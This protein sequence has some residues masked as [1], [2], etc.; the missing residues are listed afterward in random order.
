M[1]PQEGACVSTGG[2]QCVSTGGDMCVH[3][4]GHVCPQEGD[5]CVHRRGHVC[6]HEGTVC[7]LRKVSDVAGGR[8][9]SP[10]AVKIT[11]D[12]AVDQSELRHW[13]CC[14]LDLRVFREWRTREMD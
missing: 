10:R 8:R 9:S 7:V 3:R 14:G 11:R 5:V 12:V 13:G 6:P 4:R 1:C 2:R